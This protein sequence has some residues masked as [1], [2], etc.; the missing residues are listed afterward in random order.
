MN[1]I[2]QHKLITRIAPWFAGASFA[3]AHIS[4]STNCTVSREG[5]CS[6]C[7]SCAVALATLVTWAVLKKRNVDTDSNSKKQV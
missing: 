1:M 3:V 5:R 6:A 7:G 2:Q 4:A